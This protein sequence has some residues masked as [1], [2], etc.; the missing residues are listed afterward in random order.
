MQQERATRDG[1]SHFMLGIRHSNELM[2]RAIPV[3]C[4]V[5]GGQ[6]Y[7]DIPEM[8]H[9]RQKYW[10]DISPWKRIKTQHELP[11]TVVSVLNSHRVTG[12][13]P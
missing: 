5:G 3:D 10:V 7:K 1:Q 12:C 2:K 11:G 4:M 6:P 13:G 8:D 9:E